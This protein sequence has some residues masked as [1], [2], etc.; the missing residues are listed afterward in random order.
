MFEDFPSGFYSEVE[1]SAAAVSALLGAARGQQAA[2]HAPGPALAPARF[3][4]TLGE[5]FILFFSFGF[6][7]LV[8][9]FYSQY[10]FAK[11]VLQLPPTGPCI[12]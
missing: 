11:L 3:S 6:S 8:S 2:A 10:I 9:G 1:L 4:P 5:R 12:Y 7:L